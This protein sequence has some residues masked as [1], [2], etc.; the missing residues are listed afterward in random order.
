LAA[1][2]VPAPYRKALRELATLPDESAERLISGLQN[3]APFQ[4][5]E[6]L[7][8]VVRDALEQ[9][10]GELADW[11]IPALLS[12]S[13]QLRGEPGI[14]L[15]A[16]LSES[17]DL[18]LPSDARTQLRSRMETILATDAL[19]STAIAVELLT[20]HHRNYQ[21]A[22][23]L[24]DIRPVFSS[25]VHDRPNGTV[26]VETLQLQTWD[27][28]GNSETL[29][30]AMDKADL[31]ELRSVIDRALEKTDTIDKWLGTQGIARFELD[32]RAV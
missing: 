9:A 12:L 19:K 22:R 4:T 15:A 26:I 21:T 27:R 3:I 1:L 24:T 7:R 29:Y 28:E 6:E 8:A 2:S 23:V 17:A 14:Q 10:D 18:D 32:R 25:D 16:V 20:Q 5:V 31:L 13:G 30:I 11:L